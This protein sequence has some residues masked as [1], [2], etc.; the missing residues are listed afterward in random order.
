VQNITPLWLWNYSSFNVSDTETIENLGFGLTDDFGLGT[1]IDTQRITNFVSTLGATSSL[2]TQLAGNISLSSAAK[3]ASAA[4]ISHVLDLLSAAGLSGEAS[5]EH[6]KV[7]AFLS[8]LKLGAEATNN[9]DFVVNVATAMTLRSFAN[10]GWDFEAVDGLTLASAFESRYNAVF[11]AV[12]G[13]D[14]AAAGSFEGRLDMAFVSSADL[15][16]G[17]DTQAALHLDLFD[18]LEGQ[19]IFK[20][21]EDVY[22]GWVFSTEAAAFTE[23][24]NYP[25]NSITMFKGKPYGA[26]DDGIYLLEGDDDAGEPIEAAIK[27]KLTSMRQRAIKDAHAAYIGYTSSGELVLK[28][29]TVTRQGAKREDWYKMQHGDSDAFRASRMKIQRGL[30]STYWQFEI[31][32]QDGADF[33]VEDVT[34]LHEV[35]S[36]R[37]R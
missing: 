33:D 36:R 21:G 2:D 7:V 13:M 18:A 31:A 10:Y 17:M 34:I 27:T 25:F 37:I 24:T 23:Y 3:L 1:A 16:S 30:R 12:S 22:H 4:D 35:L 19:V 6:A 9:A 29:T 20:L 5:I 11:E 8:A 14:L 32:N 28:V 26:T 15:L